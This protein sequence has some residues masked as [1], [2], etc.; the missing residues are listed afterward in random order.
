ML[1]GSS[2]RVFVF[3]FLLRD[4]GE[5]HGTRAK[6]S[7]RSSAALVADGTGRRRRLLDGSR[8]AGLFGLLC[9]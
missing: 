1:A 4:V 8:M 2:G 6:E 3:G 7:V 5:G 9:F